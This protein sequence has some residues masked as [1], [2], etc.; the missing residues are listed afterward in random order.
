MSMRAGKLGNV[1]GDEPK[2]SKCCQQEVVDGKCSHCGN[3]PE[4]IK[5][6]KLDKSIKNMKRLF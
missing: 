6:S 4:E 3:T 2:L 5:E 1:Y